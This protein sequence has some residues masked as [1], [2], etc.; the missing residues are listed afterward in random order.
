MHV[1]N[2]ICLF[3]LLGAGCQRK[4]PEVATPQGVSMVEDLGEGKSQ[5]G[6]VTFK[7]AKLE[8]ETQEDSLQQTEDRSKKTSIMV[9]NS[10]GSHWRRSKI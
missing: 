3:G 2:G 5:I 9:L 6:T 7:G 1:R 4:T 8:V 10:I